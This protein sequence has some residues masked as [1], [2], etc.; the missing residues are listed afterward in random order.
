MDTEIPLERAYLPSVDIKH[1]WYTNTYNLPH[2]YR[3]LKWLIY[4]EELFSQ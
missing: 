3:H 4:Q 1:T 2:S